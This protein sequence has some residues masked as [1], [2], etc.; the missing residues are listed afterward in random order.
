MRARSPYVITSDD[1]SS[2]ATTSYSPPHSPLPTI[3]TQASLTTKDSII[4]SRLEKLAASPN[5]QEGRKKIASLLSRHGTTAAEYSSAPTTDVSPLMQAS[6]KGNFAC[7]EELI[8]A[9]SDPNA[10]TSYGWSSVHFAAA[11]GK[12]RCLAVLLQSGANEVLL[13]QPDDSGFCPIHLSAMGGHT[14]CIDVLVRNG[15]SLSVRSHEHATPLHLAAQEGRLFTI[16]RLCRLQV[17]VDDCDMT[18]C[19]GLTI[20]SRAG[21]K[22]IAQVL[23]DAG[24]NVNHIS[25]TGLTSFSVACEHHRFDIAKTLLQ[26]GALVRPEDLIIA[27]EGGHADLIEEI[28]LHI[29]VVTDGEAK[30]IRIRGRGRPGSSKGGDGKNRAQQIPR[31]S[32]SPALHAAIKKGHCAATA[33]LLQA[34]AD[35]HSTVGKDGL[36]PLHR[37]IKKNVNLETI[38]ILL[39]HGAN[40]LAVT[41]SSAMTTPMLLAAERGRL[42]IIQALLLANS[43]CLG[44]QDK[45]GESVLMKA[46]QENDTT[47]CKYLL[48]NS[49]GTFSKLPRLINAAGETV[50]HIAAKSGHRECLHEMLKDG[51]VVRIINVLNTNKMTPLHL[52]C[53]S[54]HLQI[55]RALIA[56]DASLNTADNKGASPLLVACEAGGEELVSLL[57]SAGASPSTC[58]LSGATPLHAAARRGYTDIIRLLLS[59]LNKK[60]WRPV[61]HS[62]ANKTMKRCGSTSLHLAVKMGHFDSMAVLLEWRGS[63]RTTAVVE[64]DA[65][66]ADGDTALMLATRMGDL[67]MCRCLIQSGANSRLRCGMQGSPLAWSERQQDVDM[68]AVL[69]VQPVV[70]EEGEGGE[71]NGIEMEESSSGGSGGGGGGCVLS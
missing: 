38:K 7:C 21:N 66:N 10:C 71:E 18:G 55:V 33:T 39:Q 4:L 23:I 46:A 20:A 3:P 45:M 29:E 1:E 59:T 62:I 64:V 44:Q 60:K 13:D 25:K 36:S 8:Q 17:P 6:I 67:S 61:M 68:S 41:K 70:V 42:D 30:G 15:H 32:L 56:K 50:L 49:V 65:A 31:L 51:R 11:L 37:G 16:H 28:L 35:I 53:R 52:A 43:K 24:A 47:L 12:D 40:V 58:K 9:G 5:D 2:S 19:T 54:G 14:S 69:M 63:G 34:G 48:S 22:N 27:A 26:H 57:L